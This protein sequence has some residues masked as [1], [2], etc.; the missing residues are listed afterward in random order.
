MHAP[1]L[2]WMYPTPTRYRIPDR[3][4]FEHACLFPNLSIV[5]RLLLGQLFLGL[6]S[7]II[8]SEAEIA[9]PITRG[10]VQL[11]LDTFSYKNQDFVP[12]SDTNVLA[13]G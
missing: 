3:F 12:T 1:V 9:G 7:Q 8:R 4:I 11:R 2:S 13:Y 5:I 10:W 6:F